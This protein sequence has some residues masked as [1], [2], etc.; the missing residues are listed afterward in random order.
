VETID[1][2]AKSLVG[3]E[4][5]LAFIRFSSSSFLDG[6]I[7]GLFFHALVFSYVGRFMFITLQA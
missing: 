4:N 5:G 6:Q 2:D 7:Q 1:K 3:Q